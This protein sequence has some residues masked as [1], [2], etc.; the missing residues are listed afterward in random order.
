MP[1]EFTEMGI[2]TDLREYN[3]VRLRLPFLSI[4]VMLAFLDDNPYIIVEHRDNPHTL[5]EVRCGR[6]PDF[7]GY[8]KGRCFYCELNVGSV[9]KVKGL[10]SVMAFQWGRGKKIKRARKKLL[11]VGIEEMRRMKS[12]GEKLENGFAIKRNK[13]ERLK[14]C[15]FEVLRIDDREDK[16][17]WH[18]LGEFPNIE[19]TFRDY[20][21]T[22][23]DYEKL[24]PP[25]QPVQIEGLS[26]NS[27]SIT[28]IEKLFV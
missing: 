6:E 1:Q 16:Y 15:Y 18:F 7:F 8:G 13:T 17:N 5:R 20:D 4:E 28:E 23:F 26:Q 22:P 12:V 11:V 2:H 19:K 27:L 14:N 10:Y 25:V 9:P 24:C 21:I 3:K